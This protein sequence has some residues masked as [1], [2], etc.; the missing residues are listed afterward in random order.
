LLRY[1]GAVKRNLIV[2]LDLVE[3]LGTLARARLRQTGAA[4]QLHPVHLQALLYLQLCNRYSNT[5]LA[6]AE[7]LGLTKGTVSQSL[8]LLQRRGL[9]TRRADG[10]DKRITRLELTET[11]QEL[12]QNVGHMLEGVRLGDTVAP[13]KLHTTILMLREILRAGQRQAGNRTFGVC[14]TCDHNLQQGPR[15]FWCELTQER[16]SL[17]D[18]KKIC[19]EH[20]P[21]A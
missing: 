7:F 17:A 9:I 12:I 11:G 5:P 20:E 8:M 13:K 1:N 18:I 15:T 3:R 6:L 19:R 16:L 14:R 4:Y 10:T 21:V 2:L